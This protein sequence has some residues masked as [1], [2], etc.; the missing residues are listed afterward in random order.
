MTF[1]HTHINGMGFNLVS[2][3]KL[4][5]WNLILFWAD[6]CLPDRNFFVAVSEAILLIPRD[7]EELKNRQ[8][9]R[10]I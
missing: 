9:A 7:E 10:L 5:V 1:S 8:K 4:V 2:M 6:T 3:L